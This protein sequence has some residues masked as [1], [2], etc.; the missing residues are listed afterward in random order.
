MLALI[1]AAMAPVA[2]ASKAAPCDAFVRGL[3]SW[4][5]CEVVER[6]KRGEI[7]M[8]GRPGWAGQPVVDR[9]RVTLKG[10]TNAVTIDQGMLAQLV[11]RGTKG[12]DRITLGAQAGTIT[13]RFTSRIQMGKDTARD[14][15]TF[16][17]TTA[18]HGPFNHMQRVVVTEFGREDE[19]QLANVG[20]VIRYDDVQGDGSIPGVPR[21]SIRV[22]RLP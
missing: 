9:V 21:L 22:E 10:E 15:F 7:V 13:K 12:A 5:T 2:V 6:K 14:V 19:I 1:L 11:V 4:M 3:P 8:R 18:S 17:N 20:R 16:T